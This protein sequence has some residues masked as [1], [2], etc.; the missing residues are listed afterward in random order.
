MDFEKYGQDC[1]TKTEFGLLRRFDPPFPVQQQEQTRC[2][3][4]HGPQPVAV[5]AQPRQGCAQK[6]Q[7]HGL[8]IKVTH[9][10][11][12]GQQQAH[13]ASGYARPRSLLPGSGSGSALCSG[14]FP[15]CPVCFFLGGLSHVFSRSAAAGAAH[16][17]QLLLNNGQDQGQQAHGPAVVSEEAE[18]S[19][20]GDH[21]QQPDA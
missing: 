10:H 4:H 6:L 20:I 16:I 17:L 14:S 3:Q 1:V 12:Q 5:A 2:Q 8:R 21:F 18:L 7:E 13:D 19:L 9:G 11:A 15:G